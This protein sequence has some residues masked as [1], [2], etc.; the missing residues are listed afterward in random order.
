VLPF[1]AAQ[2]FEVFARYNAA[3]WPA[4]LLAYALGAI[5]VAAGYR[6]DRRGNLVTAAV[7]AL[8]W[9]WAGVAYHWLAF[10][11]IN[12]AAWLFGAFFVA[13][14]I[15][16]ARFAGQM[17]FGDRAGANAAVGVA[18]IVYAALLYPLLGMAAGHGYPA[19]PMFGI[20]PCPVT[21]FTLGLFLLA[22]RLPR[23][24]LI[25]PVLWSLIGGTAAFLLGVPQDW[26]LLVSGPLTVIL[27]WRT[28]AA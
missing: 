21:I 12:R 7:L 26:L 9:G 20:T 28:R 11:A 2:F 13:E 25:V 27:I 24:L 4:P 14:A 3:V 6:G 23:P 10:S 19:M 5:A 18:F 22:S 1:T 15:L 16:L 8:F 17:R